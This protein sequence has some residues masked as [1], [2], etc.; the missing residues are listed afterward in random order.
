MA[1]HRF[2][3]SASNGENVLSFRRPSATDRS[4][5][6]LDLVH[7]AADVFRGI[8]QRARE[9]EARAQSLCNSAIEKVRHA[10]MRA[11][12]AE[13]AYRTIVIDAE[14]KLRDASS[15]LEEARLRL[16]AKED[17]LTAMEFRAQAAEAEAREAKQVLAHVEEAIRRRL[18]GMS[19]KFD[20]GLTA[21]A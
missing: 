19:P 11:E 18:L 1:Q 21:V 8:E 2:K 3:A 9:T 16:Q 15:A 13:C 10:E 5:A 14:E 12:A 17:Q 20:T 7:Q 4:T 6:A